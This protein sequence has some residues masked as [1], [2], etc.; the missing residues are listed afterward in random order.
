MGF[1]FPSILQRLSPILVVGSTSVRLIPALRPIGPHIGEKLHRWI[2]V[3]LGVVV[4]FY[5]SL[6]AYE[7]YTRLPGAVFKT[8]RGD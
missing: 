7:A 4:G 3:G 2:L 1:C 8:L 6:V 5:P